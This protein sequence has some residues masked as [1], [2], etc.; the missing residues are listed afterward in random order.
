M[1]SLRDRIRAV[2]EELGIT[3]GD[4]ARA[5]SALRGIVFKQQN[6][7]P[8]E[9]DKPD[10]K[11]GE[12]AAI[13]EVLGVAPYYLQTGDL[14]S[15]D[16]LYALALRLT[17]EECEKACVILGATFPSAANAK[18]PAAHPP[19]SQTTTDSPDNFRMS[20]TEWA[21]L[22]PQVAPTAPAK[23]DRPGPPKAGPKTQRVVTRTT[24]KQ[25]P[26]PRGR[27]K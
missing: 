15:I 10:P 3:Q 2:R 23:S 22:F 6:Y 18:Q 26:M 8:L 14:R 21:R 1:T 17:P 27:G 11:S 13:A 16:R 24:S 20:P 25:S 4:V 5:V 12:L 19:S 9:G 7:Q